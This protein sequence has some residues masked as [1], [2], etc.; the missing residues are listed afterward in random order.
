MLLGT[1]HL[2]FVKQNTEGADTGYLS[3]DIS[4]TRESHLKQLLSSPVN[5]KINK[6]K[7]FDSN[8]AVLFSSNM[9][10]LDMIRG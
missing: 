6:A 9:P 2:F 4:L 10:Y 3:K 5:I 8:Q 1:A 7:R